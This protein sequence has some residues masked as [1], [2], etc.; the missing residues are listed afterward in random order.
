MSISFR[1]REFALVRVANLR[2]ASTGLFQAHLMWDWSSGKGR[3]KAELD[4]LEHCDKLCS[5][6][7]SMQDELIRFLT[8]PTST[9]TRHQMTISGMKE[10]QQTM[11][12]ASELYDSVSRRLVRYGRLNEEIKT[13]GLS[14]SEMSR[15]E[16]FHNAIQRE[17]EGLR[18]LKMYRTPQALRAFSRIF[19]LILPAF[20]G[21][22]FANVAISL[23]NLGMGIAMACITT[24][25]LTSIYESVQ[26]ME[27]PFTAYV[28]LDGVNCLEE[29]FL[30][31]QQLL[32]IRDEIFPNADPF[33]PPKP[34][35]LIQ[36]QNSTLDKMEDDASKLEQMKGNNFKSTRHL[37]RRMARQS[38]TRQLGVGT[39][40]NRQGSVFFYTHG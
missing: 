25:A 27:D 1:R 13:A 21:P 35:A 40:M 22:S 7:F 34:G 28:T 2:S 37:R 23:H 29:L 19:T 36:S 11:G 38:E 18:I 31:A 3:E 17:V 33:V 30:Q 39:M 10:A 15:V 14:G 26:V 32:T 4:M 20:Y 12:V 8:L 5:E 24:L 6:M 16:Q 9:L